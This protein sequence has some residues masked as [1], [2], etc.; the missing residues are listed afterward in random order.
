M[1][2]AVHGWEE[3]HV[4][5]ALEIHLADQPTVCLRASRRCT[6]VAS[7]KYTAMTG[8]VRRRLSKLINLQ[9]LLNYF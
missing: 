9:Q 2:G 4:T 3:Q 6:A 5:A 1:D 8:G 7:E